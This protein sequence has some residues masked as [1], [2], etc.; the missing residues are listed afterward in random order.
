MTAYHLFGR[1]L[2]ICDVVHAPP[3]FVVVG[4]PTMRVTGHVYDTFHIYDI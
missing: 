3:A 1:A 4:I 2:R